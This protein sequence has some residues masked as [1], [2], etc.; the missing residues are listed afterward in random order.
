VRI[1]HLSQ[2]LIP[3]MRYQENILPAEQARLGHEVTIVASDLM[4]GVAG[5]LA[6]RDEP[7]AAAGVRVLRLRGLRLARDA[8]IRLAGLREAYCATRGRTSCICTASGSTPTRRD[9]RAWRGPV[10]ADEHTDNG[11]APTGISGVLARWAGRR[12]LRT[13]LVRGGRVAGAN[14]YAVHYLREA[15]GAPADRVDLLPLGVDTRV[16]R[17][18][19]DARGRERARLGWGAADVGALHL[20]APGSGQ[21]IGASAGGLRAGRRARPAGPAAGHRR[22]TRV[23]QGGPARA[24]RPAWCRAVGHLGGM[25]VAGGA[26]RALQRGG[27]RR[28]AGQDGRAARPVGVRASLGGRGLPGG[29]LSGGHDAGAVFAPGDARALADAVLPLVADADERHRRGAAAFRRAGEL[30]WES[31]ARDSIVLYNQCLARYSD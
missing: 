17:P 11:N 13:V 21:G 22:R 28:P 27:H 31:V 5:A 24:G 20:R 25:A 1:L 2:F 15:L 18:D 23:L 3:G 12:V 7:D 8:Q 6:L 29:V 4:P 19:G 16:F 14:P 30:S 26:E 10:L 9:L